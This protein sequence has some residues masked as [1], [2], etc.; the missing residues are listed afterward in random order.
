MSRKASKCVIYARFS[1]RPDEAT[2]DSNDKQVEICQAFAGRE[3][4]EIVGVFEDR[5]KSRNDMD[6]PGVYNAIASL[7]EGW[8]II[9]ADPTRFGSDYLA[10]SLEYEVKKKGATL[11]FADGSRINHDDPFS[12][13]IRA[14]SFAS[15]E[16]QRR[17]IVAKTRMKMRQHM[18]EGRKMGGHPPYGH[19]F[20]GN[21]MLKDRREQA[22]VEEI[23]R[24]HA[25]G[26][27]MRKAGQYLDERGIKPRGKGGWNPKTI[28][29]IIDRR[30]DPEMCL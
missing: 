26:L 1:P 3:G 16:V 18:R 23:M 13:V 4:L 17:S 2:S 24:L 21:R 28:K 9:C 27:S 22:I 30:N 19:K 6:R 8:T 11:E 29:R 7:D 12:L 5:G 20:E 25:Q 10:M 15:A 14:A